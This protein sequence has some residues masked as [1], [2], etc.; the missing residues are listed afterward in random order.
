MENS[1]VKH[2]E[3]SRPE[4]TLTY[5]TAADR[6]SHLAPVAFGLIAI[7]GCTF[8][9]LQASHESSRT[10]GTVTSSDGRS[11]AIEYRDGTG[12]SRIYYDEGGKTRCSFR[13]G[14]RVDVYYDPSNPR[15]AALSPARTQ[16][17]AAIVGIAVGFGFLFMN[18]LVDL[19][20]N[21]KLRRIHVQ[22]G[23]RSSRKRI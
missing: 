16:V 11:C 8:W 5:R 21:R 1:I 3:P 19:A 13:V 15:H 18:Q 14:Q 6:L 9:L 10:S 7:I 17:V 23:R 12:E 2:A 22:D 20:L 4:G